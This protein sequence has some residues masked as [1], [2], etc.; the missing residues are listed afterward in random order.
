LSQFFFFF[1]WAG[2]ALKEGIRQK[3][4]VILIMTTALCAKGPKV[5]PCPR[6]ICVSRRQA[7]HGLRGTTRQSRVI[8]I[9]GR[10][11]TTA[12]CVKGPFGTCPREIFLSQTARESFFREIKKSET[13]PSRVLNLPDK[14]G[15]FNYGLEKLLPHSVPKGPKLGLVQ[16][17]FFVTDR[18]A[19]LWAENWPIFF[20]F[21]V[22]A[23]TLWALVTSPL[24]VL[25]EVRPD[26]GL[27]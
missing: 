16:G 12:L 15:Y 10:K 6:E 2:Q 19:S 24:R 11:T 20:F 18:K 14:V 7:P 26:F 22:W 1:V 23:W 8:L 21:F 17:I 13:S 3:N 27:F 5:G 4:L 9:M 25:K